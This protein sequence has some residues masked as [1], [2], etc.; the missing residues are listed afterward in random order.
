MGQKE[1]VQ[2]VDIHGIYKAARDERPLAPRFYV[3]LEG[4]DVC[5]IPSHVHLEARAARTRGQG[6]RG[7]KDG[8]VFGDAGED[9]FFG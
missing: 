8:A 6:Q 4:G 2:P 3:S 9:L 5:W 7:R 1:Y